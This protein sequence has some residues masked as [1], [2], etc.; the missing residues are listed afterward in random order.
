MHW[1]QTEEDGTYSLQ[2]LQLDI[3]G[4]LAILGEGSVLANAQVSTLSAWIFLPR[5][6]PAPQAL[7]RP[8]RPLDLESVKGNVSGVWSGNDR[9]HIN[10]IGNII[11]NANN[12]SS[13][14]V[15]VVEIKRINEDP[16]KA[17]EFG[18]LTYVAWLG[19]TLSAMLL[20]LSI[21]LHD[22]MSIIATVLLS[23]LSSL[24]G[25][26][27]YWTLRLPKRK[28]VDQQ[29]QSG[30]TL[31]FGPSRSKGNNKIE[32]KQSK[33]GTSC[34]IAMAEQGDNRKRVED[35]APPGDMVIRYPKGSFLV[36]RCHE[37]VA[38]EL[39]FAPEEIEY[40]VE[41]AWIYRLLSLV[42]TMMLMGG[43]ICLANARIESQIAW[44]GSYMLLGSAYWIVAALPQK[45][46]W[47]TS[48]YSV[49]SEALSDSVPYK[50]YP[51]SKSKSFTEALWKAIV[52]SKD[53][54]WVRRE[55][56]C[57]DT[58]VWD[59]WLHMARSCSREYM[60]PMN[61][62]DFQKAGKAK[63]EHKTWQIPDWD[64]VG[65]LQYLL[66]KEKESKRPKGKSGL[67]AHNQVLQNMNNNQ[68]NM[69]QNPQQTIQ[70]DTQL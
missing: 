17:K 28:S 34:E 3:V 38:R 50:K 15:R 23:L 45:V 57:P 69:Q 7:M 48:C 39:Y 19:F 2:S 24:I 25:L 65:Y 4:F 26:G 58:A 59:D 33:S 18:P 42:G 29:K 44:A 21:H 11:C 9:D 61:D 14:S 43:V 62:E 40:L 20:G 35:H 54:T 46:H 8:T 16:I 51:Y 36:V 37:D 67:D 32:D 31:Y 22:G 70:H 47:D 10:H 68:Q 49:I 64:P 60:N 56:H 55:D 27:N 66:K 1:L 13:F 5:L 6:I 41:D 63:A 52:A 12:L 30:R 53:A